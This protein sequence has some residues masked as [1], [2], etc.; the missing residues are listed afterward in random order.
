MVGLLVCKARDEVML[1]GQQESSSFTVGSLKADLSDWSLKK[2]E[3]FHF[4]DVQQNSEVGVVP[5]RFYSSFRFQSQPSLPEIPPTSI[6]LD[7]ID[8]YPKSGDP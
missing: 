5:F 8:R 2:F 1:I 3:I 6:I 7:L 4:C